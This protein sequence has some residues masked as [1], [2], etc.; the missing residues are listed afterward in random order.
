MFLKLK[1]WLYTKILKRKYVVGV[2]PSNGEDYGCKTEGYIDKKGIIHIE[3][4]TYFK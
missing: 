4:V 2:D 1:Q 3:K